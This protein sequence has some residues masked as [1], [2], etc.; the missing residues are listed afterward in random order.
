MTDDE[1]REKVIK[2]DYEFKGLTSSLSELSEAM[3][4]LT[5]GLEHVM[6]LNEKLVSLDRDLKDSFKRVHTR[7]DK[8]EDKVDCFMKDM[9]LI[10]ILVKYPKLMIFIVIGFVAMSV[11]PIRKIILGV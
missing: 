5:A 8:I 6:V 7:A 3:K 10:R 9:E 4:K 2:H 1:I 11:D